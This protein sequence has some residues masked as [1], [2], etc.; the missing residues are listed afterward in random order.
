MREYTGPTAATV[1]SRLPGGTGRP[2]SA[3]RYRVRGFCHGH[4]DKRDSASLSIQDRD[5]GGL[6][7][8]CFVGCD[9]QTIIAALERATGL[10]IWQ[11]WTPAWAGEP[12]S[13]PPC[14][15]VGGGYPG[16]SPRGRGNPSFLAPTP[17]PPRSIP[18]WAGEP[19]SL[20][21]VP[22]GIP[23]YPRVGGGT[24]HFLLRRPSRLGLSPRGRGNPLACLLF[25]PVSRSIPAW[26][27]EP[28]SLP[29]VPSGIPVYPRVGGGTH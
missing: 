24:R 22:S 16:L 19:I 5:Q 18:A 28:I 11:A 12:I 8:T 10:T 1:A 14:S 27:G 13:L 3:G 21:P 26:A 4:G 20:P 15:F 6:L 17:K 25:L 9:R 29:P 2:D 7:V 23:V